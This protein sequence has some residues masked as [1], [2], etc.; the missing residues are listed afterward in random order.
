MCSI[1]SGPVDPAAIADGDCPLPWIAGIHRASFSDGPGVRTVVSLSG[2]PL[3]CAWCQNPD[4]RS[5]DP[6]RAFNPSRC[7]G[8]G[9]CAQGLPCFARARQPGGF[10]LS[11][12]RLAE[13][14]LADAPW[15]AD[16]GGRGL[17][18]VT[19]SGGEPLAHARYLAVAARLLRDQGVHV[20]VETSLALRVP[21]SAE[22]PG[23][24]RSLAEAISLW[25]VDVKHPDPAEYERATGVSRRALEENL[26][27]LAGSRATVRPRIVL[28][29][30][31]TDSSR[32]LSD[33]AALAVRFGFSSM[34]FI[35][36]NPP[37]GARALGLPEEGSSDEETERALSLFREM[38]RAASDS[39]PRA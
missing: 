33:L 19:F 22:N 9:G 37:P 26:A 21:S 29:P 31:I 5:F 11:A 7:V 12:K 36:Y 14:L 38:F 2:C 27:I 13:T 28:I 6:G 23:G 15:W 8:C 20:A 30:G 17:G 39:V 24:L 1:S 3:S 18:G 35:A 32:A 34:E 16:R 25:L 10:R 4:S